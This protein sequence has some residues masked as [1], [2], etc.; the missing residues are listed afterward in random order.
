MIADLDILDAV[1]GVL[2][3]ILASLQIPANIPLATIGILWGIYIVYG[4]VVFQ[5]PTGV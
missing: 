3:I 2:L 1:S 4:S 5:D